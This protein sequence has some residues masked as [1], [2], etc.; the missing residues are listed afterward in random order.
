[1]CCF[2]EVNLSAILLV[3][4]RVIY[5]LLVL[6]GLFCD[7]VTCRITGRI[8][9]SWNLLEIFLY[10]IDGSLVFGSVSSFPKELL[11]TNRITL[12]NDGVGSRAGETYIFLVL[13]FGLR[14]RQDCRV[15]GFASC[16]DVVG[17]CLFRIYTLLV[18][19]DFWWK[20]TLILLTWRIWW[21][22]NNA[23]SWKLTLI[24]LTWRM[25]WAP[26]NASRWKL[27]LILL[28][29]RMWWA[30]N[31]SSRWNLTLI[32]LTWRMW[33]APN[34]SSRWNLTLILLTWRL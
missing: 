13:P 9:P 24:L 6:W 14:L 10:V 5:I 22:P 12:K 18:M 27:T 26:N 11:L 31:N 16:L 2:N 28:T 1:M 30:P 8:F 3:H 25:W 33:W 21:A 7:I 34:N 19:I 4:K 15:D 32:L 17:R 29:W 23:S 20:L